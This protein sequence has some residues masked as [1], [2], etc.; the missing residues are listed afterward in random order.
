MRRGYCQYSGSKRFISN[1][2][3]GI[4][5]AMIA[6]TDYYII[7]KELDFDVETKVFRTRFTEESHNVILL[8]L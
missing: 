3:E 5:T 2:Y 1:S 7:S 6:G 8:R 4:H